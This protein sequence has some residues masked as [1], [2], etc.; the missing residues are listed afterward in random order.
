MVKINGATNIMDGSISN[1][2]ISNAAAISTIKL[3][4]GALFIKNDGT[5]AFTSPVSGVTPTAGA[6][7]TTKDYVDN[8]IEAVAFGFD[9]KASARVATTGNVGIPSAAPNVIDGISVAIGDRILVKDQ[10]AQQDNGIYVVQTVGTGAN[11]VWARSTD[12]N[13][14]VEVTA[15]LFVW[16]NEGTAHAESGWLLT[17]DDPIV[18]G[19]T[20]LVFQQFSGAGQITAGAGL[21]KT[22]NIL[23]VG[24][25]DG[26]VVNANDIQ[27]ASNV[28]RK[29]IDNLFT[30]TQ[31][32]TG[33]LYASGDVGI[34][35]VTPQ[36]KL[37]VTTP[38]NDYG[39]AHG[40]G[41]TS[42][43]TFITTA[44]IGKI[45]TQTNHPFALYVNDGSPNTF[46]IDTSS[47]I[48]IGTVP[49][50]RLDVRSGSNA[51][52]LHFSNSA[53][54][55]GY[56]T[57]AAAAN[58]NISGGA[59]YNGAA[60]VAKATVASI[61]TASALTAGDIVFYADTGLTVGNTYSP[62]ARMIIRPNGQVGISE[63]VPGA[64][65]DVNGDLI[66]Q[67][68]VAVNEFS[69]DGTMTGNSNLAVP[70][71]QAVKTYTDT[72][73]VTIATTQT[74]TGSK[75]FTANTTIKLDSANAFRVLDSADN[76]FL[77]VDTINGVFIPALD[78]VG[79][80]I[81][82]AAEV[83]TTTLGADNISKLTAG[84]S[85]FFA[86]Q[87]LA[88][89]VRLSNVSNPTAAQD[90]A[91][92]DYVDDRTLHTKSGIVT[93]ASFAG[94]PKKAT[95]TFS[96]AFSGT[97]YT[98]MPIGTGADARTWTVESIAAGS[99]VINSNSN[100]APANDVRWIAIQHGETA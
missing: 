57:S 63:T 9:V 38:N 98:P 19:T 11:G 45:G 67:L 88:T 78:M 42:I 65:L 16:V 1:L 97:N 96:T 75:T 37:D 7:L 61:I 40:D 39:I 47:N 20:M 76:A 28:A 77:R 35:N 4:D 83:F 93:V 15:G 85:I 86:R 87:D 56:L 58:F 23:D 32:I 70:T 91:T 71:E 55:G 43:R 68:G 100:T 44:G 74:V 21:T 95:V 34:G 54:S 3:A 12:A 59:Q 8:T 27:V 69:S 66:L 41:T 53:D 51:S 79:G 52:Q 82:N 33:D 94:N 92:K 24:Q 48:G 6:H 84:D 60:W 90:A 80:T 89:A 22:G 29:N 81:G 46:Y 72:T 50:Y 18:V 5:V 25:G 62:N 13:A 2:Q 31:T 73:F 17:A 36:V 49:L 99:F 10:A 64:L 26:I 14:N 30:S